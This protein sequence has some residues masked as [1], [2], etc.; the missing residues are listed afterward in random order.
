MTRLG[1][2]ATKSAIDRITADQRHFAEGLAGPKLPE[3]LALP[4]TA[5]GS[6]DFPFQNHA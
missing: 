4:V 2:A 1:S 3:S 5:G 6:G